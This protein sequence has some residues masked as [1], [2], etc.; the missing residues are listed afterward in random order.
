M[1]LEPIT[2]LFVAASSMLV[3]PSIISLVEELTSWFELPTIKQ[4]L[5][6]ELT[7]LLDPNILLKEVPEDNV[8][9]LPLMNEAVDC[10]LL[11]VPITKVCDALVNVLLLPATVVLA[12]LVKILFS[13]TITVL[14]ELDASILLLAPLRIVLFLPLIV[15]KFPLIIDENSPLIVL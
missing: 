14:S 9:L 15:L 7:M 2:I 13:P 8:L 11:R 6:P 12:E 1:L 10:I 5:A 3:D 4:V